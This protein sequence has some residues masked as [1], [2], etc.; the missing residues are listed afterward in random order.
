MTR[1]YRFFTTDIREPSALQKDLSFS[2]RTESE[3]F[4]Q[5]T[6]VLRVQPGDR[7]VLIP[8]GR[9]EPFEYSFDVASAHKK[10]VLLQFR[11]RVENHNELGFPLEL[12]LCLPNKP[13]KLSFMVQ[14]AVEL[15]VS[16]I[17]L[18]E[19]DNSQ[20][21][22]NLRTDR[23]EKIVSEA[24]EQSERVNLPTLVFGG[25]L[26]EMLHERIQL[27]DV[28]KFFVA[29]ERSKNTQPLEHLAKSVGR[30]G[31]SIVV[32]PEGGFSDDEK[33]FVRKHALTTFSLGKR[34]LR[35]ETAL[36]LSLGLV[37]SLRD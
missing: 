6:R 11:E 8:R 10:E 15:G 16:S 18:V 22:H 37:S 24:A 12:V 35:M 25:S 3:I 27:S 32:G 2:E 17:V 7:V 31:C 4:S 14:K 20:M 30:E 13:D 34:I 23:L 5:L 36:I 1:I 28:P 29:M 21:K 33:E 9:T 19:G 26:I